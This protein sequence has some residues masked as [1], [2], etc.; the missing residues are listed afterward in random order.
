MKLVSSQ[1]L[2][3]STV[4]PQGFGLERAEQ[5]RVERERLERERA[6]QERAERD[7][8]KQDRAKQDR[9]DRE[10]AEQARAEQ[11]RVEQ[12]RVDQE[13]LFR[14]LKPVE[15]GYH[16]D[17][18]CMDG[19]RRSLLNQIMEWVA[20]KSGQKGVLQ[21]NTYWIYGSPGIGKTAL[22]HS[23]CAN[24]HERNHLVGGFFCRRD[25]K[26]LS[27]PMNI[28]PTFIHQLAIIF[29]PF[30]TIVA[31]HLRDDPNLTPKSMEGS[32]FLDFVR[33]LPHD[34]EHTLAFVID[35]LD[36]CGNHENRQDVLKAL[37]DAAALAPW[38]KIIITSRPEADIERFFRGFPGSP[39]SS[40]DLVTD[41]EA[42]DDLRTFARSQFASVAL[43]WHIR[44][45]WPEES[46]F[47]E[48]ISRANGL[49][50]FIKTLILAFGECADAE[51]FLKEALQGSAG[52][53]LESL[54]RLYSSILKAHSK[55]SGFWRMIVVI[56]TAQYRP[57]C[58]EPIAKLA[59][60][61]RNLVEKW[62]DALS[63]LLYRDEG[64]NGA[65]R[66]RHLSISDFFLSDRCEYQVNLR[67][68]HAQQGIACL[69]TMVKELRFNICNL[70]DSR[71]ANADIK[72]LPSRA[73]Q[74][75]SD[76]LQ[77]SCLHWSDHIRFP[78]NHDE[79]VLVLG[80][81]NHFFEGL[82]PI[83][84]VEVLSIMGVI[85][86]GAQSIRR[87]LSSVRVSTPQLA[88]SLHSKLIRIG[89]R[90]WNQHFLREFGIF[91][92]SWSL[93]TPPSPSALHTSIFQRDHSC[94]HSHLYRGP[95]TE[96]LLVPSRY[97]WGTCRH[98]QHR[99]WSGLDTQGLSGV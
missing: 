86:I 22:A 54:Y 26:N 60:V 96:N 90:M 98:G 30:R 68:S 66:V 39:Y 38:L 16:R 89:C 10:R 29:P 27:E 72:D 64:A 83:F 48:L 53:G 36:E 82:Y 34:P 73:K 45:A 61:K 31:K 40:Y 7:R 41:Q 2:N 12:E 93:F 71:L 99:H 51:E 28:L 8:A 24:L 52:T 75:I 3:L 44:T 19:T 4:D 62:V 67:E 56:T 80:S 14:R 33:S 91:V 94:P 50:I 46:D 88:A 11:E 92:T 57:L 21:R 47:N 76:P 9:A 59:G 20:N 1:F 77:Y 25:D 5:E 37:I 78:A 49:F 69:E 43:H 87:L 6:E 35:A 63:S 55:I 15:T 95:S 32:L 17:L 70:E 81:L 42:S 13:F 58:E 23:I 97:E 74:N 84:W 85:P 79:R 18:R 65:I